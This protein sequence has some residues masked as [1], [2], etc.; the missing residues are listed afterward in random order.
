MCVLV[1][2]TPDRTKKTCVFLMNVQDPI[3][4]GF[5]F[6]DKCTDQN[7]TVILRMNIYASIRNLSLIEEDFIIAVCI[8]PRQLTIDPSKTTEHER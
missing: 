2:S 1:Y 4:F 3:A 6:G 7:A 5:T 8:C